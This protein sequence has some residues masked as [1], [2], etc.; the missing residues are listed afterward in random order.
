MS[1]Q[2]QDTL[3]ALRNAGVPVDDLPEEQRA[4]LAGL[5]EQELNTLLDIRRRIEDAGE[6]QGYRGCTVTGGVLF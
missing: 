5:S 4:A 3:Q 2:N 1:M 6:V